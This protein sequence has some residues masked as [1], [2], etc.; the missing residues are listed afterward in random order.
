VGFLI[1]EVP[2]SAEVERFA[3]DHNLDLVELGLYGGEEYELVVTVKPELWGK[4]KESV[5]KIGGCL[6]GIGKVTERE[7]VLLVTSGGVEAVEAR[8][9]EHFKT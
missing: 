3:E 7:E 4:A 9:W 1:E 8:G 6:M 2:T 5:E